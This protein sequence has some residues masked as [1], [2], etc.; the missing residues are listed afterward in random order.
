MRVTVPGLAIHD[1]LVLGKAEPDLDVEQVALAM[2]VMAPLDDHAAADDVVAV[3]FRFFDAVADLLFQRVRV[4]ETVEDDLKRCL[5]RCSVVRTHETQCPMTRRLAR[6]PDRGL[7]V[8]LTHVN[9]QSRARDG[10][11]RCCRGGKRS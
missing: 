4:V 11:A 1:E 8:A 3:M 5:H 10:R 9:A 6:L 2:A 7:T